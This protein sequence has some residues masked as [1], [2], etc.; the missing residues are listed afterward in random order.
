LQG[1]AYVVSTARRWRSPQIS[2]RPAHP[3]RRGAGNNR[4]SAPL[5]RPVS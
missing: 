3:D 4:A 5:Q 2:I 1:P